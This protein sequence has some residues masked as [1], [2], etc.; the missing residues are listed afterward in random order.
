MCADTLV[1]LQSSYHNQ[2][3]AMARLPGSEGPAVHLQS[4]IRSIHG[5]YGTHGLLLA[6]DPGRESDKSRAARYG[7]LQRRRSKHTLHVPES[8]PDEPGLFVLPRIHGGL[9]YRYCDLVLS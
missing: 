2:S 9:F 1:A 5:R 3:L 6:R 8:Q 4:D 7:S